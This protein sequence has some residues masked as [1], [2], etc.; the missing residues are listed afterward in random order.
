[1]RRSVAV[2]F[3]ALALVVAGASSGAAAGAPQITDMA[4]DAN[5][6]NAGLD[7]RPLSYD[8]ADL[9]SVQFSTAYVHQGS[10]NVATGLTISFRTLATPSSFGPTLDY[11]L[12]ALLDGCLTVFNAYVGGPATIPSD[13]RGATGDWWQESSCDPINQPTLPT[14]IHTFSFPATIDPSA[15]TVSFTVS[16]ASLPGDAALAVGAHITVPQASDFFTAAADPIGDAVFTAPLSG[17]I[18]ATAA[19]SSFV[20]GS[21][22]PPGS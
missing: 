2:G 3:V 20:I 17:A 19:G 15:H 14:T 16:F 18:D 7:T 1:M 11:Q 5:G 10:G 9:L 22:V 21:D 4:G 6:S 12:Q 8:P 13:T